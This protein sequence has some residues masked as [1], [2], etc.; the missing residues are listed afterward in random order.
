MTSMGKADRKSLQARPLPVAH[1]ED[2]TISECLSDTFRI[3]RDFLAKVLGIYSARVVSSTLQLGFL[4]NTLKDP[5]A[6][7][8]QQSFAIHGQLDLNRFHRVWME[9]AQNHP[10]L[11]TKFIQTDSVEGI[12]FL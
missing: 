12:P 8:V 1:Y 10:I 7:M 6:Y 5:S 2:K 4:I 9:V 3:A 11:R